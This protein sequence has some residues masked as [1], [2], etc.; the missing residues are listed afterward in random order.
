MDH[1]KQVR[2]FF[3]NLALDWD[4]SQPVNREQTIHKLLSIFDE[5]IRL[6]RSIL[7]IGTGTGALI[8]ILSERYPSAKVTS[9]DIAHNMLIRAKLRTP[10]ANLTQCDVHQIPF[11]N[12]TFDIAICHN[13]FPHFAQQSF[14][15]LEIKRVLTEEGELLILHDISRERVNQ[16]H[17]EAQN[18]IIHDHILPE[19]QILVKRLENIG[20]SIKA[21]HDSSAHF[22]VFAQS[23]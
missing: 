7:E 18:S 16:I 10:T 2:L 14:A 23:N 6:H 22:I 4:E 9:I 17:Q 12:N 20:F 13:C 15:L 1:K 21:L 19:A 8:P 5:K 11:L 3:E